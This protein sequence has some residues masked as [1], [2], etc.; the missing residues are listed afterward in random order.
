MSNR[1]QGTGHEKRS[2]R[3]WLSRRTQPDNP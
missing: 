3:S 1:S 2:E